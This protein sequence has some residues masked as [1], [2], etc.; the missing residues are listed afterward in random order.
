[1]KVVEAVDVAMKKYYD[2]QQH[3]LDTHSFL[4]T[5]LSSLAPPASDFLPHQPKEGE[6]TRVRPGRALSGP[7][8][9]S[10]FPFPQGHRG[11]RQNKRDYAC[12]VLVWGG[13]QEGEEG[14][15]GENG[16]P[17]RGTRSP[18][19]HGTPPI[20]P[21]PCRF[22]FSSSLLFVPP[23]SLSSSTSCLISFSLP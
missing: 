21:P 10:T 8:L 19:V 15:R 3:T 1:M 14:G 2:R 6:R 17:H 18:A 16:D 20:P 13:W 9:A 23:A 5:F 12:Y 4:C 11:G 7:V 22:H